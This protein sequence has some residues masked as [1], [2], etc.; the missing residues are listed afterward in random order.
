[1]SNALSHMVQC[2]A[3]VVDFEL[4][5]LHHGWTCHGALAAQGLMNTELGLALFG[6]NA[7]R[8][9]PPA[10]HLVSF[11]EGAFVPRIGT[12]RDEVRAMDRFA[13]VKVCG[14][15][16]LE[17]EFARRHARILTPDVRGVGWWL[18]KPHL[19]LAALNAANEA[20]IVVYADVGCVFNAIAVDRFDE[21]VEMCRASRQ[22]VLA[23]SQVWLESH[24]NKMDLP[25]RL[26]VAGDVQIMSTGQ[27]WAG[28]ILLRKSRRS[29][30]LVRKWLSV[31]EEQNYR[32]I[33]DAPS[34]ARNHPRFQ[35]HRHDQ[36]VFSLIAKQRGV[37]TT[38]AEAAL[39]NQRVLARLADTVPI[40]KLKRMK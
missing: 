32:F 9:K 8:T 29:I 2:P 25:H 36:S 27:L 39:P 40:R 28:C 37:A 35:E 24:W 11:A 6:L 19:I 23:F 18:W 20:D 1:M 4:A 26:G 38:F 3:A 17:P 7:H 22:G 5:L 30:D 15:S 14:L 21:Y 34:E 16:D 10:L 31:C 12:F 13:S 33:D